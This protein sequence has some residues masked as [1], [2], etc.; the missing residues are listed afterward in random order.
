MV[1]VVRQVV[2]IQEEMPIAFP[3]LT[4]SMASAPAPPPPHLNS[5]LAVHQ[6]G[7]S[8]Q[9]LPPL[10]LD[11]LG[12]QPPSNR[13]Q[14]VP[15]CG[16]EYASVWTEHPSVEC[17]IAPFSRSASEW[18]RRVPS[19]ASLLLTPCHCLTSHPWPLP[20]PSP[21]VLFCPPSLAKLHAFP[22]ASLPHKACHTSWCSPHY[23]HPCPHLL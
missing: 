4:L 6:A 20:R 13:L 5:E 21:C 22:L 19:S 1:Q 15:V 16:R 2:K 23:P 14:A 3:P 9:L 11:R 7:V 18:S 17:A 12:A 8:H 10:Q